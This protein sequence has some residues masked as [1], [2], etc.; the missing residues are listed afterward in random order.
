LI[1]ALEPVLGIEIMRSR[2]GDRRTVELCNGPGKL[3]EALGINLTDNGTLLGSGRVSVY[4]GQRGG[5][6]DVAV[7]GRVGLSRGHD[8]EL[9]YYLTG[10]RFVSRGRTGPPGAS[11]RRRR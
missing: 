2:R 1:R 9:R 6:S 10:N 5:G 3:A 8:L 11:G 4:D 7:T